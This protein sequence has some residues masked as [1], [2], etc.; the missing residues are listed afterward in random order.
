MVWS[1][2]EINQPLWSLILLLVRELPE[3]TQNKWPKPLPQGLQCKGQAFLSPDTVKKWTGTI[4]IPHS[5]R[6]AFT[7]AVLRDTRNSTLCQDTLRIQAYIMMLAAFLQDQFP[8]FLRGVSRAQ[9]DEYWQLL[10]CI[11]KRMKEK[12]MLKIVLNSVL[13]TSYTTV[14]HPHSQ[15]HNLPDLHW[16][17]RNALLLTQIHPIEFLCSGI[18]PQNC[19]FKQYIFTW[20]ERKKSLIMEKQFGVW[21][22]L[23]SC[24]N[25]QRR[26]LRKIE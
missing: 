7:I 8:A 5:R 18:W 12:T 10:L 14:P 23:F 25:W 16:E 3:P 15:N 19:P 9:V 2:W 21:L 24:R 11:L 4:C 26:M 17:L 13:L 1:F 22:V 20:K 6:K